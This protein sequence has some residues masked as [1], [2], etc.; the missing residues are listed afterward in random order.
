MKS[1]AKGTGPSKER[2]NEKAKEHPTEIRR[3][4]EHHASPVI[5]EKTLAE[6]ERPI[7]NGKE[8]KKHDQ[9]HHERYTPSKLKTRIGDRSGQIDSNRLARHT[10][11]KRN[12]TRRHGS[13]HDRSK[14]ENYRSE[15]GDAQHRHA[16]LENCEVYRCPRDGRG[17]LATRWSVK[18]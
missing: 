5:E 4:D 11:S 7:G 10:E 6:T 18:S 17:A 15:H 16:Q 1:K 2:E 14:K 12:R 8:A 3:T 13:K 9:V